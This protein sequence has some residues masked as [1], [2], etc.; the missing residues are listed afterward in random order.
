[1][2]DDHHH[3]DKPAAGGP[4]QPPTVE[5]ILAAM[6]KKGVTDLN[7]LAS[8]IVEQE[9]SSEDEPA[10]ESTFIFDGDAY[11]YKHVSVPTTEPQIKCW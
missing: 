10:T 9:E 1:M 6:K 2:P 3:K 4:S 8:K 5:D 11:I 7:T